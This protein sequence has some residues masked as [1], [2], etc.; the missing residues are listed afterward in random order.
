MAFYPDG[1]PTVNWYSKHKKWGWEAKSRDFQEG[2]LEAAETWKAEHGER[3]REDQLVDAIK[4]M[5]FDSSDVVVVDTGLA[6]L[7]ELGIEA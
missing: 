6:V 7:E 3:T 2:W 5:M 1:D 4:K